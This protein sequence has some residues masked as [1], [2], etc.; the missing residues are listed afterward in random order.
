MMQRGRPSVGLVVWVLVLLAT[1]SS[2][3]DTIYLKEKKTLK[4]VIVEEQGD[5]YLLNTVDGE[6]PVLKALIEKIQYD[7]PEQSYYQLGR[8][9][10]RAGRLR[11]ALMAY[12]KA[13]ELQ[14]AFQAAR[15]AA[16]NVQ[17]LLG[18]QEESQVLAEIRQRRL[19]MERVSRSAQATPAPSGPPNDF[20]ARFGCS[21]HYD[22]GWTVISRVRPN[23]SAAVAGLRPGDLLIQIW[24][25]PMAHLSPAVV[26]E[27]L[28]AARGELALTIERSMVLRRDSRHP[29]YGLQV[30]VGYDGLRVASVAPGSPSE[31][32]VA[33]DLIVALNGHPG[34][35]LTGPQA[36]QI[37]AASPQLEVTLQRSV[38]L[39]SSAS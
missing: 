10:Q 15:E 4:G 2:F 25:E 9:L 8:Q 30:M 14:P 17:R 35:Y 1:S 31:H 24:N 16:F 21:V 39:R 34:R 6:I 32:L 29:L 22:N 12:E 36:Q 33:G 37:L 20:D 28:A 5:R 18:G 11:E 19:V 3:A 23:S 7:D 38:T 26:G 27:R 13:A